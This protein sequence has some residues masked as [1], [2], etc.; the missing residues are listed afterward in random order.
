MPVPRNGGFQ[1]WERRALRNLVASGGGGASLLHQATV[2][3]TD[4][5][6]KALPTTP[7]EMVAAPGA[8]KALL[9]V[10][11]TGVLNTTAGAYSVGVG[12]VYWILNDGAD[13]DARKRTSQRPRLRRCAS[14]TWCPARGGFPSGRFSRR[15]PSTA[16]RIAGSSNRSA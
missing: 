15:F 13:D 4:A 5:Q 9:L 10:R 11:G 14:S 3:L 8:N 1:A 2:S 6:I 16:S 12:G 7:V